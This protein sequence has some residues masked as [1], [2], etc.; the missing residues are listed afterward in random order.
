[1]GWLQIK[2]RDWDF[3]GY[4]HS[5]GNASGGRGF[6]CSR[7]VWPEV[8]DVLFITL[9]V[10]KNNRIYV[11]LATDPIIEEHSKKATREDFNKSVTGHIYRTAKVKLDFYRMMDIKALFMNHRG[12]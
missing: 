9:R 7:S 11:K 1:M 3:L 12:L 8:G 6:T 4:W 5:K 2:T 10:N